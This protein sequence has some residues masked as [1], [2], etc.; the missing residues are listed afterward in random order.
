MSKLRNTALGGVVF[1]AIFLTSFAFAQQVS[2]GATAAPMDC[3]AGP[4]KR[5]FAAGKWLVYGCNDGRSLVVVTA[6]ANQPAGAFYL[7]ISPKGAGYSVRG[8]G[9]GDKRASDAAGDQLAR[10]TPAQIRALW[11]Q[12]RAAGSAS[13]RR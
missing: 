10:L 7:L 12:T 6:D 13:R 11:A 9:N 3:F 8:E 5:T 2:Q 1:F 4:L